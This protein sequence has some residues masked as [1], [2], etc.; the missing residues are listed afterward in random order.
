MVQGHVERPGGF[1]F[2]FFLH[3]RSEEREVG[4]PD[5]AV[6]WGE[7][8]CSPSPSTRSPWLHTGGGGSRAGSG[9]CVCTVRG[10]GELFSDP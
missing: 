1:R 8:L 4:S 3:W 10:P 7:R 2:R 6:C 9:G 5:D